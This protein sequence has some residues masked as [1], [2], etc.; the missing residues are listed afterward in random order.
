MPSPFTNVRAEEIIQLLISHAAKIP[1]SPCLLI[2][3]GQ[4]VFSIQE[5]PTNF[6]SQL[7]F[8]SEFLPSGWDFFIDF[9]KNSFKCCYYECLE[10]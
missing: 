5:S 6:F 9:L 10:Y 4:Y 2:L 8:K 3:K 1:S 7:I